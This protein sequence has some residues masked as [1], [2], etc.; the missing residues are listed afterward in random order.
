MQIGIQT[1]RH[2]RPAG[3]K[4]TKKKTGMR[5]HPV[6]RSYNSICFHLAALTGAI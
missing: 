5:T 3:S 2:G 6:N 4:K 1:G